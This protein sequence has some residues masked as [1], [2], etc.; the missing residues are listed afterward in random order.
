[1]ARPFVL[2]LC[3]R[4]V[5]DLAARALGLAQGLGH[6]TVVGVEHLAH[7]VGR[8]RLGRQPLQQREKGHRHIVGAFEHLFGRGRGVAQQRLGQP[9]AHVVL[10]LHPGAAQAVDGQ[11]GGDGDQPGVGALQAVVRALVPAQ[12]GVLHHLLGLG[13]RTQ[14]AVGNALQT[15]AK[16][17]EGVVGGRAHGL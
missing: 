1:M 5:H 4:A 12:P 3:F 6:F 7:Q 10:A 16:A 13:G 15:R 17:A 14:H 8:A 9:G 2:Q 11:A